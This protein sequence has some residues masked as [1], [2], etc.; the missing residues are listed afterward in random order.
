LLEP[1]TEGEL[2]PLETGLSIVRGCLVVPIPTD[3]DDEAIPGIR[4][5]ILNRIES[6]GVRGMVLDLSAVRVLDSFAFEALVHTARMASLLGARTVFSGIQ[7]GVASSLVY[8]GVEA[9][10]VQTARTLEDAFQQ[11]V[12]AVAPSSEPAGADSGDEGEGAAN[13]AP[14]EEVDAPNAEEMIEGERGA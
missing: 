4:T 9:D 11:L 5:E 12:P 8:L 1:R 3:L 2:A 6:T 10:G 14:E 7:P 13:P